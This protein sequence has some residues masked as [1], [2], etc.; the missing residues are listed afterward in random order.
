LS[1]NAKVFDASGKSPSD[2]F[3]KFKPQ[4]PGSQTD[5]RANP[6]VVSQWSTEQKAYADFWSEQREKN[7]EQLTE[8]PSLK[9]VG[10]FKKGDDVLVFREARSKFDSCWRPAEISTKDQ[11]GYVLTD[12]SRVAF[13]NVKRANGRT[14]VQTVDAPLEV[15]VEI[16]L[17]LSPEDLVVFMRQSGKVLA[18]IS[19]WDGESS[20]GE[21]IILKIHEDYSV[22]EFDCGKVSAADLTVVDGKLEKHSLGKHENKLFLSRKTSKCLRRMGF[23]LPF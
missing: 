23:P 20:S 5:W 6:D 7:R 19:H 3:L 2:H 14:K 15:E 17:S 4:L 21:A 9:R 10:E 12:G 16:K 11:Y 13:H 22:T 18:K 1:Q 8:K